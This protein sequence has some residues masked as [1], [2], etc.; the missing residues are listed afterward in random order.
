MI[1]HHSTFKN[2]GIFIVKSKLPQKYMLKIYKMYKKILGDQNSL[3]FP[4]FFKKLP[5]SL[6]FPWLEKCLSIFPDF[7][8]VERDLRS[9]K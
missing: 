6:S 7:Q 5:N 9:P 1:K 4:S 3:I 8:G 2:K